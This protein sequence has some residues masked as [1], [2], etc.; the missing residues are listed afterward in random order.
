MKRF[1]VFFEE[2]TLFTLV[3]ISA[4]L[5][6]LSADERMGAGLATNALEASVQTLTLDSDDS[7]FNLYMNFTINM[8]LAWAAL[9][10]F[11]ASLGLKFDNFIARKIIKN[12]VIIV[13]GY[14]WRT[15][16][17]E[18][19]DE[20]LFASDLASSLAHDHT[21]LIILPVIEDHHRNILWKKGVRVANFNGDP[22][23]VLRAAR[24]SQAQS[25]IAL[26]DDPIDN[27]TLCRAALSPASGN[28]NLRVRCLI[29]PFEYKQKIC[30]EDFFEADNLNQVKIFNKDELIAKKIISEFPPDSNLAE[31]TQ[32][33]HI[34]VFGVNSITEAI[35][36]QFARV[37]HYRSSKT[38][39]ITVIG[40]DTLNR[41]DHLHTIYP[42][43]SEW[44][45]I[46]RLEITE[47]GMSIPALLEVFSEKDFPC[48]AYITGSDEIEN[49]R[50]SRTLVRAIDMLEDERLTDSFQI[51]AIDPPGGVVL[52]D[53][54]IYGKH[55]EIFNVF[56]LLRTEGKDAA[57]IVARTLLIDLD[58]SIAQKVH[59]CYRRNDLE[60]EKFDPNHST[61][62]NSIPWEHLPENIR[63]ANRAVADHLAIK[64]RAVD[65]EILEG[66]VAKEA[67]LNDNEIELL[68]EM[69][70]RRWW[71]DRSLNGW[72]FSE[73]RND[74][75]R[76]H[77]NM[78]PY[79]DLN[80]PDRQKDRDSV[81]TLLSILKAS[82][83]SVVRRTCKSQ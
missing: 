69:E 46:C 52:D 63:D 54:F 37:G 18:A 38:P 4:V 62:P 8:T 13:S 66:V 24:I 40:M 21:V 79:K 42:S 36:L 15:Q 22:R 10:I 41:I 60:A 53:F 47:F 1:L 23:D 35:I 39:K 82:G 48:I 55:K 81:I 14:T 73:V 6:L 12:H 28:V 77:P 57:S 64:L 75:K 5:F 51:I 26:C 44:I 67:K 31:E 58:D 80:D 27:I 61:H 43:L 32:R 33:V 2:W 7:G 3:S 72:K 59:E 56:S 83:K 68:A 25:L 78:I 11:M 9:K 50:L 74:K 16:G 45:E 17:N 20:M 70:H 19:K 29:E 65:C 49:L 71:A 76:F 34:L 30:I